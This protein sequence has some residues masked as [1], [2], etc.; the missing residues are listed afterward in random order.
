MKKIRLVLTVL[1]FSGAVI[2]AFVSKAN[3]SSNLIL[4]VWGHSSTGVCVWRPLALQL[5]CS[6]S[7]SGAQCTV[8]IPASILTGPN[9]VAPAFNDA[10]CTIVLNRPF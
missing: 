1:A 10:N 8:F 4:D 7:G 6:T 3:A 5:G 2:G 9:Q